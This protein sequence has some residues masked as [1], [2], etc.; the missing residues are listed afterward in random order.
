M[1]ACL[2][3][4]AEKVGATC[5]IKAETL[6][7]AYAL[8]LDD[9]VL[10]IGM[11]AC[12]R[13]GLETHLRLSGGGSDGNV[14]NAFGIPTTVVGCGMANIHRHDEYV[15]ISDMVK[16]AQL[17]IAIVQTAAERRE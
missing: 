16:S 4:E 3:E 11:D 1:I 5:E 10:S 8:G 2:Q 9:P 13:L 7:Q 15:R 14:F 17:V 6:Y 12:K